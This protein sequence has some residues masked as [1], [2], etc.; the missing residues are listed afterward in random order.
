VAFTA[1]LLHDIGKLILAANAEEDYRKVIE[2]ADAS[3]I[4]LWAAEKERFGTTHAQIGAYLFTLWGF[5]DAVVRA[6]E[7]HHNLEGIEKFSPAVAI[8]AAQC[9]QRGGEHE[10]QLNLALLGQLGLAERV[11]L[12]RD[13]VATTLI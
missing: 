2:E 7:N 13:K 1:G 9:L 8:H 3:R 12:W 10:K 5:P 6:V 4:P 11:D